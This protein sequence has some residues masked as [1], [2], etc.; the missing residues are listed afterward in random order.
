MTQPLD[1]QQLIERIKVSY[2]EVISDLPP[3]KALPQC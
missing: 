3:I 1:E 2:Q